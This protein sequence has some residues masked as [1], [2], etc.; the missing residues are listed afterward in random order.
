MAELHHQHVQGAAAE[1]LPS[2]S[3]LSPNTTQGH[4]PGRQ[5][6]GCLSTGRC[7]GDNGVYTQTQFQR[8]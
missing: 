4:V 8:L 6:H 2:A 1:G 5:F 7:H 3:T